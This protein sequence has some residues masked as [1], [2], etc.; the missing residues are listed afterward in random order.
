MA[1]RHLVGARVSANALDA[2]ASTARGAALMAFTPVPKPAP[3]W[4]QKAKRKADEARAIK[5]CYAEVDRRD[6]DQCRICQV[7]VGGISMLRKRIHHHLVFRSKLG[8][9][10]PDN[11]LSICMRC[12]DAIHREGVLKVSGDANAVNSQGQFCGVKVER[13]VKN[14]W[15]HSGMV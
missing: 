7:H 5:A 11:V 12:D 1:I 14:T 9:H 10:T 8:T 6:G 4:L 2:T 15:Q 3:R 13:L